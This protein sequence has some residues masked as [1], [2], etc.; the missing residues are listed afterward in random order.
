MYLLYIIKY[1]ISTCK[2][3]II[4]EKKFAEKGK[5]FYIVHWILIKQIR[6]WGLIC[7]KFSQEKGKFLRRIK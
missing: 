3:P 7:G 6:N 2:V 5:G 4:Y 1:C